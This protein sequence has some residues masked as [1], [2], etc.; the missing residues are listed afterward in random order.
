MYGAKSAGAK[1][2]VEF[3]SAPCGI[4]LGPYIIYVFF[5]LKNRCVYNDSQLVYSW[6][7]EAICDFWPNSFNQQ[8]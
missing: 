4:R 5:C 6:S 3:G 2:M 7:S 8:T 1:G